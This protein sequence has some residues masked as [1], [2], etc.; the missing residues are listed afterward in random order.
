MAYSEDF[1]QKAIEYMDKGHSEKELM[2]AFGIR[3]TNVRRWR[4][5][6]TESGSLSPQYPETRRR[7]IDLE[8]LRQELERKP[9]AILAELAAIFDCAI[10]SIHAALKRMKVTLKKRPLHTKKRI[11]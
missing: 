3:A 5:L 7:K 9:D 2:E 8:Q 1:R 11:Q 6:L 4:K 10:P